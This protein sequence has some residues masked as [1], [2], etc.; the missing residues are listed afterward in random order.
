MR[1]AHD[2]EAEKRSVRLRRMLP[3]AVLPEI[4]D[5]RGVESTA[6]P[7]R[8]GQLEKLLSERKKSGRRDNARWPG[9][10]IAFRASA[11]DRR[12]K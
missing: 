2:R 4:D 11:I 1:R 10:G 3:P 8:R 6:D 5:E 7:M 12:L 9:P